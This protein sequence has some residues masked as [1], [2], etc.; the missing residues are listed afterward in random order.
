LA[1]FLGMEIPESNNVY[2]LIDCGGRMKEFAAALQRFR[3]AEVRLKVSQFDGAQSIRMDTPDASFHAYK[4]LDSEFLFNGAVAGE[5]E[6]VCQFTRELY[7]VLH[8]A[9]FRTRFDVYDEDGA[10]L[11]TIGEDFSPAS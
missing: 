9:G 4:S 10:T 2:G 11:A 8:Q 5:A 1:K 3:G 7:N 6:P